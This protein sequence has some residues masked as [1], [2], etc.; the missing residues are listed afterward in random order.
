MTEEIEI[1]LSKINKKQ[2]WDETPVFCFTSDV[3]WASEDVMSEY[4]NIVNT[5]DIKPTLFVTHESKIIDSNFKLGKIERGIHPNFLE[6]SS[7]GKSFREVIET[8]I[9]FA[10]ESY[11]FRSHRFFDVTDITHMFKNEYKYKYFSNGGTILQTHIKPILH[12]S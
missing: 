3:D 2:I 5:L 9:K 11:V 7:H 6:N 12:E 4:F 1:L 8:C 10:P